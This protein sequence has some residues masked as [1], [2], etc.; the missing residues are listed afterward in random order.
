[1]P[2]RVLFLSNSLNAGGSERNV[3][4]FCEQIDRQRYLPEVWVFRGGGEFEAQVIASGI[5]VRNLDRTK[6]NSPWFAL[7]AAYAIAHAEVDLIHAFHPA[8]AFY[9]TL[10][11]SLWGLPGPLI[12]SLGTTVHPPGIGSWLHDYFAVRRIDQVFVNSEAVR[13]FAVQLGHPLKHT[14]LLEN[15]HDLAKF[16]SPID[17]RALRTQL[18]WQDNTLGIICVG[19][20]IDTKRYCDLVTAIKLLKERSLPVKAVFVGEGPLREEHEQQI[21]V[22]GL[23]DD[24]QL[25]GYRND[26]ADLLRAADLFAY[27]SVVEGLP[28][29]VI[30]A[31][32]AGLPIV[33]ADIPGTRDVITHESTG[34]LIE[35]KQPQRLADEIQR[36]WQNP[37]RRAELAQAAQAHAL[38]R[39]SAKAT[40]ERLMRLYDQALAEK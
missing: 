15:G 34:L 22:E 23:Q 18:N 28:N 1:M 19:R 38:Q 27:P 17:R 31:Q 35:P 21:R 6:A 30:E 25:L 33:A 14:H 26:I 32:L 16:Q 13:Q 36:L 29:S 7:K 40:I 39:F 4:F 3:A 11:K 5:K 9:A 12:F 20:L 2:Q 10:A 37:E 24:I 8:I